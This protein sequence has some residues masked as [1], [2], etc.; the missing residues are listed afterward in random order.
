MAQQ[1]RAWMVAAMAGGV[2]AMAA[3]AAPGCEEEGPAE[4]AGESLDEGIDD[5]GDALDDAGDDLDDAVD[6]AGDDLNDAADDIN[7]G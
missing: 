1:N 5:A 6:D 4:R 3:L 7:D 2:L